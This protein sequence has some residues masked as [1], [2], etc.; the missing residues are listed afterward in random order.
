M[1]YRVYGYKKDGKGY[2][3][4]KNTA[5]ADKLK[6]FLK[7]IVIKK[8]CGILVIGKNLSQNMDET[9]LYDSCHNKEI[10]DIPDLSRGKDVSITAV[11]FF[12]LFFAFFK[13]RNYSWVD[14]DDLGF[15]LYR[16][17]DSNEFVELL[18]DFNINDDNTIKTS[19]IL[20][21]LVQSN[22]II[23]NNSCLYSSAISL[24]EAG[25]I[26]NSFDEKIIEE[27]YDLMGILEDEILIKKIKKPSKN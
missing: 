26:I 7:G 9:I 13:V 23:K 19:R 15:F 21:K 14:L 25:G 8:Y 24:T 12:Y 3:L 17:L 4:L 11:E 5:N 20:K 2:K 18:G 6:A 27:F 1:Y 22:Y 16:Y 10:K